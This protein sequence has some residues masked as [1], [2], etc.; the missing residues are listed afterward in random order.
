MTPE[1]RTRFAKA[2]RDA[3]AAL[4][5]PIET[6]NVNTEFGEVRAY[7]F[8]EKPGPPLVLLS[9][10]AGTSAMYEPNIAALCQQYSVYTLDTLGEPGMSVQTVPIRTSA[11]QARWL[12]T[13]LS[14]LD[15]NRVHMVGVS[16]G[17][18]QAVN[19]ALHRPERIAS[20]SVLDPPNVL[21][22]FSAELMLA[23]LATIP[24][25]PRA[26]RQWFLRWISGDEPVSDTD[27][28]AKVIEAGMTEYK[29]LIPIP[30]YPSDAELASI[31]MPVLAIVAG[32][33]TIHDPQKAFYRAKTVL[34]DGQAELWEH[35]SHAISG[36]CADEVNARL[37]KFVE[38]VEQRAQGDTQ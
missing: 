32:R 25:A 7:R 19:L 13:V 20:L 4:P 28:V 1:G 26:M 22:R 34:H 29:M 38:H 31:K 9:G 35:A 23:A 21:A 11:D 27:P 8:S 36:E 16:F 2:Y 30:T 6:H 5:D 3:M 15:L 12:N 24:I 33:S 17:G 10:R 37:L 14:E 18:W